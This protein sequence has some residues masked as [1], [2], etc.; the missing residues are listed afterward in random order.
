MSLLLLLLVLLL[1]AAAFA[2][3]EIA[4][5]GPHGWAA[6]LPTW[7]I[8]GTWW[9]RWLF[10]GR[11]MTGYHAWALITVLVLLHV[12]LLAGGDWSLRAEVRVLASY[13]L[14]WIAEDLLWF[15]FNPAW[16]LRRF[17]RQEVTWHPHWVFGMPIEYPIFGCAGALGLAWSAGC[18]PFLPTT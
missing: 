16:G 15:V 4:I 5:E 11:V 1:A 10:G 13:A 12:G 6:N 7:R 9:N 18:W 8:S 17:N 2:K 3:L 14:F